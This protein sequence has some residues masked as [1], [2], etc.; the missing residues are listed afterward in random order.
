MIRSSAQ[1]LLH[2]NNSIPGNRKDKFRFDHLV[3]IM[4]ATPLYLWLELSFGVTLLDNISSQVIA[5]DTASIEHWGRIISGF[6]VALLVLSGWVSQCE[7]YDIHWLTRVFV[8]IVIS[9]SCIAFTWWFQ[10][11]LID[12]YVV[13]SQEQITV[14]VRTLVLLAVLAFILMRNWLHAAVAKKKSITF[15]IVIGL[16]LFLTVTHFLMAKVF[17]PGPEELKAIGRERQQAALLTVVRRALEEDIYWFAGVEK[18]GRLLASPEGKTFLALFPIFGASMDNRRFEAERE[19]MIFELSFADWSGTYGDQAFSAYQEAQ[20]DLW[21]AYDSTY[22][23]NPQPYREVLRRR[24]KV[25]ANALWDK[26][27]RDALDGEYAP[28]GLTWDQFIENPAGGKYLRKKLACFDCEF[29]YGMNRSEFLRELFRWTQGHNVRQTIER[30]DDPTHFETGRDGERAARTYWVP[31]WALLFSML[32]AFTHIFKMIFT[33]TEYA[34]LRNFN[35]F[36]AAD[37]PLAHQ[38]IQTSR[39][40]T[41][42]VVAA[43]MAVIY[44]SDN[45]IT[46]NERYKELRPTVW[47][48]YPISGG[49][50]AHWTTN[51]QGILYPITNKLRPDWMRFNSDPLEHVPFLGAWV[52]RDY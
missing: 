46:G 4:I 10:G 14:A 15:R 48:N 7:K 50:A 28:P 6:A 40:A 42:A 23:E 47:K 49:I 36:E 2:Q 45:R 51:A 20:N 43:L 29:R 32:G 17:I 37:S 41:A 3:F 22:V 31:F 8:G 26:Q 44:L 33:F 16:G 30:L 19:S 38:V 12:F 18:D 35:R 13:R 25:A 27:I 52:H 9:L 34:H 21:T 11:A 24:G 5:E 1:R 39:I